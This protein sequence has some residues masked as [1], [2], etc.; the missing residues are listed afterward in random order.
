VLKR[1]NAMGNIADIRS[2]LQKIV[3]SVTA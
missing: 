1:I 2:T 3:Q